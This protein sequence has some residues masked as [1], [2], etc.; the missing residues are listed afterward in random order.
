MS[1][2]P[3]IAVYADGKIA[4]IGY[5]RNW[6][7]TSLLVEAITLGSLFRECSSAE[8]Y[9]EA[10]YGAQRVF[11]D[12]E[13]EKVE[14]TEENMQMLESCSEFPLVVDLTAGCVYYGYGCLDGEGLAARPVY[15]GRITGLE[16]EEMLDIL[17]HYSIPFA[18]SEVLD[19]LRGSPELQE[20]LSGR[21]LSLLLGGPAGP[22]H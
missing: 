21:T 4:D 3:T 6:S 14:N 20:K 16:D 17:R 1:F 11:Y 5:Y 7:G 8:E 13:P 19:M 9:R 22:L 15:Q 10:V 2:R 18:G 12:R